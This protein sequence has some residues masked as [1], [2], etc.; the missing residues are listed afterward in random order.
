MVFFGSAI[1]ANARGLMAAVR[2]GLAEAGDVEGRDYTLAPRFAEN[3]ID[4]LP[5][6]AAEVVALNPAV[7]VCGAVDTV[8][9]ARQLTT[10]IPLVTGA[11]ADA[12]Q[13]G[14]VASDARPSRNV[15][16]VMP[17]IPGCR[18]SRSRS[19]ARC[20]R[21]LKVVGILGNA[22]DPKAGPPA[23]EITRVAGNL[24]IRVLTPSCPGGRARAAIAELKERR[25]RSRSS[26][27]R[28]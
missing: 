24:G 26:C 19:R 5:S 28:A 21:G 1:E 20:F 12:E 7:I 13:L 25:A 17:Y 4:L 2:E 11:L 16:G 8:L 6:I 22:N 27:R 10:T 14:L 9:A 18:R 15:T 3:R 23:D